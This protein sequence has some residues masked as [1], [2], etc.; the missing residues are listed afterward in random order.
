MRLKTSREF[1]D[2]VEEMMKR[3]I[4]TPQHSTDVFEAGRNEGAANLVKEIMAI[5]ENK[6]G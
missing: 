6:D 5:L 4:L 1:E 2:L 3:Y